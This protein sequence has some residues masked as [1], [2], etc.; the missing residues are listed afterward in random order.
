M[1]ELS[2]VY[3][4]RNVTSLGVTDTGDGT[5]LLIINI[6]SNYGH[7]LTNP[8]VLSLAEAEA[9]DITEEK[10]A[11]NDCLFWEH[12]KDFYSFS[13]EGVKLYLYV[14]TITKPMN[15][16][17]LFGDTDPIMHYVREKEDIKMIVLA[18][19][20]FRDNPPTKSVQDELL[21]T[22][23]MV[24]IFQ[25]K[26]FDIG[27]PVAAV[28]LE[29]RYFSGAASAAVDL[30]EYNS[31]NTTVVISRDADRRKVLQSK[32]ITK[33]LYYAQVCLPPGK[34]SSIP[35]NHNFGR[36]SNH[37]TGETEPLPMQNSELSN[38]APR[39][40]TIAD[41]GILSAYRYVFSMKYTDFAGNYFVEEHTC[42]K[43][44]KSNSRVSY[45]RVMV[46]AARLVRKAGLRA[47]KSQVTVDKQTGFMISSDRIDL[48]EKMEKSVKDQMLNNP[49]PSRL[50]EISSVGVIIDPAQKILS[51]N[52]LTVSVEI[53]PT[54]SL[55]VIKIDLSIVNPGS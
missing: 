53:V 51:T 41:M 52:S 39:T 48:K 36:T 9:M 30:S 43:P 4:R 29:G 3:A 10:D 28:F 5:T 26:L 37:V 40:Y 45:N 46:K 50:P 31:G 8:F 6:P 2:N 35:V 55:S 34:L 44:G 7:R 27:L 23:P 22:L 14:Y 13:N 24:E 18:Q 11:A 25:Q 49:D 38:V 47:L 33:A 17:F 1:S 20:P 32:G 19:N 12:I 16:I 21:L 42:T 15:E 54:A